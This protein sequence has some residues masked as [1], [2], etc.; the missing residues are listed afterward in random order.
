MWCCSFA[1]SVAVLRTMQSA[2]LLTMEGGGGLL[3][4]YSLLLSTCTQVSS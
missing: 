4:L 1:I 3:D 2:G